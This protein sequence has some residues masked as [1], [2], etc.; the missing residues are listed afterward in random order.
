[1]W[2]G[3]GEQQGEKELLKGVG[4]MPR[5]GRLEGRGGGRESGLG[6]LSLDLSS[7][8]ELRKY[9]PLTQGPTHVCPH[10]HTLGPVHSRPGLPP[11]CEQKCLGFTKSL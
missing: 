3:D 8:L 10:Q 1:M 4:V 2:G 11:L 7:P 9:L 5:V 6:G